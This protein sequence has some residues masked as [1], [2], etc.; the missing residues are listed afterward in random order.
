MLSCPSSSP[1]PR[2]LPW[3]AAASPPS[4]RHSCLEAF[5]RERLWVKRTVDAIAAEASAAF[6]LHP[7]P[8]RVRAGESGT[9]PCARHVHAPLEMARHLCAGDNA[10]SAYGPVRRSSMAPEPSIPI[11]GGEMFVAAL[12]RSGGVG[13]PVRPVTAAQWGRPASARRKACVDLVWPRLAARF[14]E[15]TNSWYF[16][17]PPRNGGI[18]GVMGCRAMRSVWAWRANVVET[19]R[20]DAMCCPSTVV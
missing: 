12:T 9:R 14:D 19:V 13:G 1:S 15:R 10:P 18:R 16:G 3:A 20:G 17:D 5:E 11:S 6:H 8:H 4:N 2:C 7:H